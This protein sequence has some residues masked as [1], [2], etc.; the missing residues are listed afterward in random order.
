MI[1]NKV[2]VGISQGDLNGIGLEIILKTLSEPGL[3][4]ICVPILFSSQKTVSYFRKMLNLEE[5]NFQ[6]FD[7]TLP[8]CT[9]KNQTFLFVTKKK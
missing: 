1:E 2:V 7:V 9:L 5:F 6:S 8:M 4:E 3:S